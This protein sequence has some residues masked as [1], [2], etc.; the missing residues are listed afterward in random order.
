MAVKIELDPTLHKRFPHMEPVGLNVMEENQ[1][2]AVCNLVPERDGKR[3]VCRGGLLFLRRLDPNRDRFEAT[4]FA[5]DRGPTSCADCVI[6]QET[7]GITPLPK[8][9]HRRIPLSQAVE[10]YL[11]ENL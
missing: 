8:T 9:P 4:G 3:L 6:F 2:N 11:Q 10:N 1:G 5:N 7:Y